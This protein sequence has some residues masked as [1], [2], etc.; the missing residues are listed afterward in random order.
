LFALEKER[1]VGREEDVV[2]ANCDTPIGFDDLLIVEPQIV[3][4]LS[5]FGRDAGPIHA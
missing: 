3:E 2:E 5:D 4:V 1:G